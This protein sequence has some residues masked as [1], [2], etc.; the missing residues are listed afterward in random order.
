MRFFHYPP[1][2][3]TQLQRNVVERACI[4]ANIITQ[5]GVQFFM[6]NNRSH[7]AEPHVADKAQPGLVLAKS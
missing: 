3:N 5:L 7:D 1:S 2:F 4:G 6:D